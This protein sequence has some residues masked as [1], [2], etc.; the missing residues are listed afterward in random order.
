MFIFCWLFF[1]EKNYHIYY[2]I[3]FLYYTINLYFLLYDSYSLLWFHS[4]KT[5]IEGYFTFYSYL[6]FNINI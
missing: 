1:K 2:L 5:L 3:I 6:Y 4:S